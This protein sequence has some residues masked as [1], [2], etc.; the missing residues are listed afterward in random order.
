[1]T[2]PVPTSREE[3]RPG[4]LVRA[5]SSAELDRG[6]W[7]TDRP[8]TDLDACTHCLRCWIFCPDGAVRVEEGKKAGTDERYC[9]G[10]GICAAE[11]P[12]GCIEMEPDHGDWGPATGEEGHG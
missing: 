12:G 11:C 6:P 10:C 2:E 3:V 8:V 7:R 1:M 4:T 9:K 5:G